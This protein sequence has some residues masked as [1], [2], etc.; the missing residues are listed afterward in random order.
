[1]PNHLRS[2][3]DAIVD[4]YDVGRPGYPDSLF[5]AL[6]Q[7]AGALRGRVVLEVGAGTGIATRS[8]SARGARTVTVDV[9]ERMLRRLRDYQPSIPAVLA[10]GHYLPFPTRSFEMVCYAQTWHWM[11]AAEAAREAVRVVG[12]GGALAIWWNNSDARGQ[13]WWQRQVARIEAA[14]P[15]FS[16]DYRNKAYGDQLRGFS[17]FRS[18]D[19][20]TVRWSRHLSI[21][22]YL[23]WLRS[24]SYVAAIGDGLSTFLQEERRSLEA[25]F[26]EGSVEEPFRT[27]LIVAKP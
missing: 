25:A 3:F 20:A 24:K 12:P 11:R 7:L 23:S 21:A 13:D 1:M 17:L 2:P 10:D 8:L 16:R 5:D 14:N 26:P 18:M 9:G 19:M 27:D 6:E 15:S 22:T 4:D